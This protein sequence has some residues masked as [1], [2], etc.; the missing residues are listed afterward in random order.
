MDLLNKFWASH[1]D[2]IQNPYCPHSEILAPFPMSYSTI[3]SL[4]DTDIVHL[5]SPLNPDRI[6]LGSILGGASVVKILD[7][8][9]KFGFGVKENEWR[10]HAKAYE[11]INS[12]VVRVPKPYRF[13][14][15]GANGYL[16]MEYIKG[17][18]LDCTT[19][20]HVSRLRNAIF[21]LAT[22]QSDRPG[23]LGDG[24]SRGPLWSPYHD[25]TP[26]N[27]YDIEHYYNRRLRRIGRQ[28]NIKG[29]PFVLVHGDIVDRNIIVTDEYI[30][31]VD[32]ASAGFY[33]KLFERCAMRMNSNLSDSTWDAVDKSLGNL[34][35]EEEAQVAL[36]RYACSQYDRFIW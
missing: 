8:A 33:P 19:P 14:T 21:H 13:F 29:L 11:L 9:V 30:A 25:F 26:T 31:L 2:R 24:P 17:E 34:N 18:V 1:S 12:T 32:W 3:D 27:S 10:N 7:V 5:C 20:M 23:S 6:I 36:L 28:L 15:S 35:E 16:V 22:I 4:S